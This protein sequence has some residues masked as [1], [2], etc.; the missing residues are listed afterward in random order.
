MMSTISSRPISVMPSEV[1][2]R[3][4]SVT[5]IMMRQP[6]NC[7]T[8]LII[9]G[10]LFVSPCWSV[11]TSFVM[12]LRM[13]P[14]EVVLKYFCGTRFIFSDSSPRIR[15]DILSVTVAMI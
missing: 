1:S 9:V 14:C 3:R 12:R 7:V 4:H 13:S 10:R 2:A 15:R 8:A 6:V 5:N 11:E